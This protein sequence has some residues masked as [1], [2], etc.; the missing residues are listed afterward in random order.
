MDWLECFALPERSGGFRRGALRQDVL[1]GYCRI[2][3][4][5]MTVARKT[6]VATRFSDGLAEQLVRDGLIGPE[7]KKAYEARVLAEFSDASRFDDLSAED[8]YQHIHRIRI[9]RLG[10]SVLEAE[11]DLRARQGTVFSVSGGIDQRAKRD[12]LLAGCHSAVFVLLEAELLEQLRSDLER[13]LAMGREVW[14]VCGQPGEELPTRRLLETWLEG[15]RGIRFCD[16]DGLGGMEKAL[17]MV[18]GEEGLLACRGLCADAMVTAVPRGYCAQAVTN[19]WSGEGCV[20]YIPAGF[21]ISPH[22]PLTSKTRLTFSHLALLQRRFGDGVYAMTVEALYRTYPEYFVNIYAGAP[23]ALPVAPHGADSLADFDRRTDEGLTRFLGGFED[24]EYVSAYF[25]ETLTRQ[26]ICYRP[27]EKQNGILVQAARVKKAAGARVLA[28]EK[29]ITPRQM[30]RQLDLP[31][32]ALVSNFLFFMTP[33]LGVLYNDL[34]ADRPLE[35]ADAASGHLDYMLAF[36]EGK[37]VETF[38]L[39]GKTCVGMD[40]AGRFHFWNFFLGGGS[41]DISGVRYHWVAADVNTS[42]ERPI[43]VYTPMY[44][45]GDRDAD[46]NTYVKPVGEGRVNVVMLREKVACVRRGDVALPSVGV[47]LSLTEWAAAPLLAKCKPLEDGYYDVGGLELTV[48]LDAP[49]GFSEEG[50]SR[51]QWAYGGGLTLIRGG[52]GIC[53]GEHMQQL[54][55]AEGWMTPLSRQTQ[56]SSLHTLAKHPR[57]AIGC[58]KNG[59]LLVLVFSGRTWR[60]SGADYSEMITIARS[61][62]PDVDYLMNG[63]GG[64]SAMLGLT[65]EGEFLELS[66]PSTSANSCAGQVRPVNTVFYIPMGM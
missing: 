25:D 39:F 34:R 17:L 29:G 46:R 61:L 2:R 31:G 37:R 28:C 41:V 40:D 59:D 63:D 56:E 32:T 18:Y 1:Y 15:L 8:L 30:F 54:L 64:G 49:D 13:A 66:C 7:E 33:K 4:I 9:A 43:R 60:S 65:H 52:V 19:L 22:V 24:A 51:M 14:V 45:F 5:S 62:Y 53:D 35:Q 10:A 12:E 36:R 3:E 20:V 50:W 16:A 11:Q 48:K 21:D 44:S 23:S 57:T 26:P 42:E 38:P 58:A 55:E 27:G 47:V 6:A